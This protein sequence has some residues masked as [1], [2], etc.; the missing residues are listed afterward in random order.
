MSGVAHVRNLLRP[1]LSGAYRVRMTGVH[2]LPR[3]GGVLVISEQSGLL[4][5]TILATGL[6]RPVRVLAGDYSSAPRWQALTA[7]LGRIEV[8]SVG[9][10]WPAWQ[11]GVAALRGGEAVAVFVSSR[12]GTP[13]VAPSAAS[14][15]Y[16][17]ALSGVPIVVVTLFGTSGI[18]PTDLPRPRSVIACHV[19]SPVE[20]PVPDNH[21]DLAMMRQH[22]ERIRQVC[23]DA[24][25][26]AIDRTGREY[27]DGKHHN[28]PRD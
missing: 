6:T 12:L 28:G 17:H 14:A 13:A 16:L 5:S 23:A 25:D 9:S 3:R 4:D 27:G 18:R 26:V 20:L 10:V 19:S 2:H 21:V 24:R 1:V 22:A 7:V 15:A 8:D 11:Q